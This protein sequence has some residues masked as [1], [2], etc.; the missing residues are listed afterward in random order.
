MSS[1]LKLFLIIILG[2]LIYILIKN[3]NYKNVE[4]AQ[5]PTIINNVFSSP[6]LLWLKKTPEKN[7]VRCPADVKKCPDSSYVSR[8]APSCSFAPC[9]EDNKY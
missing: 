3:L 2:F 4:S 9:P 8:M 7:D 1:K 6:S 5:F